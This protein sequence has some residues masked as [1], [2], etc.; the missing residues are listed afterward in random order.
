MSDQS[1]VLAQRM[2][3]ALRRASDERRETHSI[4]THYLSEALPVRTVQDAKDVVAITDEARARNML[5][6]ET[7]RSPGSWDTETSELAML[8][9]RDR[10]VK[11]PSVRAMKKAGQG[12]EGFHGSQ[13]Q[14]RRRRHGDFLKRSR[15]AET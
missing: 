13:V 3:T 1:E 14:Q 10:Y 15:Y 11:S 6:S 12:M 9:R 8:Q 7:Q 2:K 5:Q 4:L